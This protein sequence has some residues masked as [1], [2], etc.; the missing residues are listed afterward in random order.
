MTWCYVPKI[1]YPP[2][3]YI[4]FYRIHNLLNLTYQRWA[5]S[6]I[7]LS[8]LLPREFNSTSSIS[9]S[10]IIVPFNKQLPHFRQYFISPYIPTNTRIANKG[11][12]SIYYLFTFNQNNRLIRALLY[13]NSIICHMFCFRMMHWP[14]YS[15]W[16][17]ACLD[18]L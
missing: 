17:V 4:P 7:F 8:K 5:W 13:H 9:T 18:K 15:S 11:H 10:I 6:L 14:K 2:R 12:L 3:G 16:A 1:H